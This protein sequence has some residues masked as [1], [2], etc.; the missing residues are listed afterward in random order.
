MSE[1]FSLIKGNK[2][3]D[4]FNKGTTPAGVVVTGTGQRQAQL[5][6]DPT[7]STIRTP[8]QGRRA[9]R[10]EITT[11]PPTLV[12][13]ES[14]AALARPNRLAGT[15]PRDPLP[16]SQQGRRPNNALLPETP[17][18][19]SGRATRP[20]AT[21]ASTLRTGPDRPQQG[22]PPTT[23]VARQRREPGT[24]RRPPR[25]NG[26]QP[27][28]NSEGRSALEQPRRNCTGPLPRQQGL[29]PPHHHGRHASAQIRSGRAQI[30]S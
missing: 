7:R 2:P 11:A 6:R 5:S 17:K 28:G 14:S 23:R 13:Q 24:N 15:H 1:P 19:K 26:R 30:W 20:T 18:S 10:A 16:E 9:D 29:S 27:A 4:A 21:T 12:A 3:R 8:T 22:T 25:A